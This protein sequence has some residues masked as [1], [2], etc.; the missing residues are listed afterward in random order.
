MAHD[1]LGARTSDELGIS[2]TLRPHPIQIALSSAGSFAIGA[3][4][5]LLVTAIA[6]TQGLIPLCQ[7]LHWGCK[8]RELKNCNIVSPDI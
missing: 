3:L 1:A 4:M 2:K 5:P 8:P 7:S 6:L